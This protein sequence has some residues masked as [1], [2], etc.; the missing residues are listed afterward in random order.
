MK[1]NEE[2]SDGKKANEVIQK[3]PFYM[4][5]SFADRLDLIYM[6][7]GTLGGIVS[8][9]AQPLMTLIFGHLVDSF[10]SASPSKIVDEVAKVKKKNPQTKILQLVYPIRLIY[11]YDFQAS[12]MF[13]YLAI[14]SGIASF[15]RK[16]K[17]NVNSNTLVVAYRCS[18]LLA[19]LLQRCLAG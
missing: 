6:T 8:G 19:F 3:V 16:Y 14:G 10:G 11:L 18:I 1:G 7:L 12:L 5:F 13:V 15:L 17:N 9:L 2:A 4:L